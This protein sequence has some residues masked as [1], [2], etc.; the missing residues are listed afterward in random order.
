MPQPI[1]FISHFQLTSG[2]LDAYLRL[3]DQV[4]RKLEA[5]K[6]RTAAFLSY[7]DREASRVTIVH[8]FAD[9]NAMDL[10]L[11]GA[12]ERSAVAMQYL[13]P[14]GW[15]IY[16]RASATASDIVRTAALESEATLTVNADFAAGFLRLAST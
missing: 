5:E 4:T 7:I 9:A 3:T 13:T 10:H 2:G 11:E 15:E 16:G 8:V 6:P 1:V 14:I 12:Q